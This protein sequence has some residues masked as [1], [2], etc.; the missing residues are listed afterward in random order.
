MTSQ[1][2]GL[3]KR[4][5]QMVEEGRRLNDDSFSSERTL[6]DALSEIIPYMNEKCK[7]IRASLIHKKSITL[8]ECQEYFHRYG[9]PPPT[10]EN[11]KVCM[12]P[13]GGIF[14]MNRNGVDI[15]LLIIEDK[16]QG[17]NDLLHEQ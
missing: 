3:S 10:E 12:K 9:G 8:Y 2:D 14:I 16:V 6:S 7:S 11:K 1:S 5:T 17:T 13:D 4:L 15:P